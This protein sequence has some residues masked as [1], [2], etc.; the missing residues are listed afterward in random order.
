MR[1]PLIRLGCLLSLL[2]GS[3]AS[4]VTIDWT[5]VGDPGNAADASG[6]G[7]VRH[8]YH[9]GTYEITNAQYAEFLGAV[10][11]SDTHGLYHTNMGDAAAPHYGGITQTGSSG[12]Y[13]YR[14]IAGRENMPVNWVSFWDSVRFANWMNNG[15]P[16]GVQD[17]TTTESGAYTITQEGVAANSIMR[18]RD[19]SIVLPTNHEWYKAAYYDPVGQRYKLIPFADGHQFAAC[20]SPPGTT[21]Y[22]ANCNDA[23]GDLTAAREATRAR[24]APMA[25]TIRAETSG[26]GTRRS[27]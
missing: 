14:S 21:S 9:I 20:E 2:I 13:E 22:S 26:S 27:S 1:M 23:V 19:A 7:A 4:A 5:F 6:Y 3:S 18:D 24:R 12:T 17:Q 15:Q 25:P 10:A 8:A 16:T 11:K